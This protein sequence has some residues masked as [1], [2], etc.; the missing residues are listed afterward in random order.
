M[1]VLG[2]VTFNLMIF[3]FSITTCNERFKDHN[4]KKITDK[5]F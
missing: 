2:V 1:F 4:A 3:E 5:E